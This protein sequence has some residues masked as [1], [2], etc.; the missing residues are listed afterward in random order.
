M[1]LQSL[2]LPQ[3]SDPVAHHAGLGKRDGGGALPL[4]ARRLFL[5]RLLREH[6][7]PC[8]TRFPAM[9]CLV[10]T[11][12]INACECSALQPYRASSYCHKHLKHVR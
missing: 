6:V 8:F 11:L 2:L 12:S 5:P 7:R 9:R 1:V 3:R 10:L 4:G